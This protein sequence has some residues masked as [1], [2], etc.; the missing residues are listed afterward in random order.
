MACWVMHSVEGRLQDGGSGMTW[1]V[2]HD[3]VDRAW[4][5]RA[6]E[7]AHGPDVHLDGQCWWVR[8]EEQGFER[9]EGLAD[10]V[11]WYRAC[12]QMCFQDF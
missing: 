8:T 5:Q 9:R 3:M 4:C 1:Q 12:F 11:S 10:E 2:W 6:P 7:V